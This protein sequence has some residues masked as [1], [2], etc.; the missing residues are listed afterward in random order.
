M[1]QPV[2]VSDRVRGFAE[3]VAARLLTRGATMVTVDVRVSPDGAL[4]LVELGAVNSW[5]IYG[6]NVAEFIAATE[7]EALARVDV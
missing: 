3:T 2:P 7:A 6:S 5:G 4:R 1:N